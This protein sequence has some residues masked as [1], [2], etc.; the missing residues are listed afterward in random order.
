[1]ARINSIRRLHGWIRRSR[2]HATQ[3]ERRTYLRPER[4]EDRTVPTVIT[5]I[6]TDFGE[7]NH[8]TIQPYNGPDQA[9]DPN[10]TTWLVA[11][12]RNGSPADINGLARALAA[13][14]PGDQVLTLDWSEAARSPLL[15]PAR[16][17]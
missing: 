1:M 9:I 2:D 5:G 14:R 11:H 10:A 12:G 8:L 13:E 6:I 17:E 3:T 4:L 7:I 16:G 15:D